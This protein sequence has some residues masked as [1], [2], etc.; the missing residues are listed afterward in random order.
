MQI[1]VETRQETRWCNLEV[2]FDAVAGDSMLLTL[3]PEVVQQEWARVTLERSYR[4]FIWETDADKRFIQVNFSP[5]PEYEH[6]VQRA[7]LDDKWDEIRM[8]V[9]AAAHDL[10]L[11]NWAGLLN[12]TDDFI[13]FGND[14][15]TEDPHDEIRASVPEDK[16]RRLRAKG[17][18]E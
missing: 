3:V 2:Y 4:S 12:V 13:V 5:P 6:F 16:L 11:E 8:L 9:Y 1:D 10:N 14:Y 7:R 17:L 18:I 15:L